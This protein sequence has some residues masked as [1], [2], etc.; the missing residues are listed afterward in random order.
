[1]RK[2]SKIISKPSNL[3]AIRKLFR[4][5]Q[6]NPKKPG[7]MG[8]VSSLENKEYWENRAIESIISA[9]SLRGQAYRLEM[10]RAIRLLA[11]ATTSTFEVSKK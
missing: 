11:L 5:C 6:F 10:I 9:Q 3:T 8:V 1:M 7:V 2:K 4:E